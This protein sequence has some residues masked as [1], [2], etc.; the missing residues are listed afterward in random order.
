[1]TLYTNKEVPNIDTNKLFS[2]S[3]NKN[4]GNKLIYEVIE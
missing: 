2:I 1:M 3:N 4:D